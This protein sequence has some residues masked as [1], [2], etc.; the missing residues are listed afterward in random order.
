MTAV[1]GSPGATGTGATGARGP[2]PSRRGE[3][4]PRS[5]PAVA[6]GGRGGGDLKQAVVIGDALARRGS[7]GLEL[8]CG[9]CRRPSWR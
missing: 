9:R 7:T 1:E 2:Q 6:Q 3:G 4:P 8:A 5:V